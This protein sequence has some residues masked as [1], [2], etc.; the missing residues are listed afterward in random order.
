MLA[1][2]GAGKNETLP[3][4]K[5]Q[6]AEIQQHH[7]A[8]TAAACTAMEHALA[9]GALLADVKEELPHGAFEPWVASNCNFTTRTARRYLQLHAHRNAL[10]AGAGVK[11][12]LAHLKTDTVSDFAGMGFFAPKW[13]PSIG[14]AV[15]H[16]DIAESFWIVWLEEKGFAR[17]IGLNLSPLAHPATGISTKRPIRAELISEQLKA[18][19]L[20]DPDEADW[21]P[22]PL[23]L[24]HE[25]DALVRAPA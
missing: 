13:L 9:A 2:G 25:L 24:A 4:L 6:A 3:D 11:A 12:A 14:K 17:A 18:M 19:E 8:I 7:A 16:G 5:S 21:R 22:I 23:K 10:P 15:I 1:C 20:P